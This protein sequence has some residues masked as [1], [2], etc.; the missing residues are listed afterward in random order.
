MDLQNGVNTLVHSSHTE[1]YNM[2]CSDGLYVQPTYAIY[3]QY[4]TCVA[5]HSI[6]LPAAAAQQCLP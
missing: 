5:T 2:S 1:K 4:H 6:V 3:Q